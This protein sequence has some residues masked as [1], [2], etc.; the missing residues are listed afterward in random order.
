M[1]YY[2]KIY[3][4]D[5]CFSVMFPDV[6]GAVTF[7]ETVE[8]ALEMAD[9]ALNLLLSSMVDESQ[10]L[11]KSKIRKEPGYYP[12]DVKPSIVASAQIRQARKAAGLTQ[13][14]MAARLNI[15]Y[16]VYQKLEDPDKSNPTVKTLSQLARCLGHN[17]KIAI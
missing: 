3:P 7:G 9:E 6:P 11:P 5:G 4:D 10:P 16:Q 14:E 2:C 1:I 17:L 13:K 15:A 8:E 12:I